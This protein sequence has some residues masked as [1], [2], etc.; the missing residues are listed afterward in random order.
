MTH[1]D[2]GKVKPI[3]FVTL[4][5]VVVASLTFL[6]LVNMSA[7][8]TGDCQPTRPRRHFYGRSATTSVTQLLSESDVVKTCTNLLSRLTTKNLGSGS[9][10]GNSSGS[11]RTSEFNGS[12]AGITNGTSATLSSSGLGNMRS[13]VGPDSPKVELKSQRKNSGG[14]VCSNSDAYNYVKYK[15]PLPTNHSSSNVGLSGDAGKGGSS[16]LS[17]S[18]FG[19][20]RLKELEQKFS[21]RYSRIF[22]SSANVSSPSGTPVG[23]DG[24]G[25]SSGGI[26]RENRN[27]M[28]NRTSLGSKDALNTI[29]NLNGVD[30]FRG[31]G[32]SKSASTCGGAL[33]SRLPYT[34][35]QTSAYGST[36]GLGPADTGGAYMDNGRGRLSVINLNTPTSRNVDYNVRRNFGLSKSA[37]S[38]VIQD[39]PTSRFGGLTNTISSA[40]PPTS[41]SSTSSTSKYYNPYLGYGSSRLYAS[42]S[43][44]LEPVPEQQQRPRIDN[45]GYVMT[46]GHRDQ[47]SSSVARSSTLNNL[48][49]ALL[50]DDYR[51]DSRAG[52]VKAES[53]EEEDCSAASGASSSGASTRKNSYKLPSRYYY[54]R[55]R[56]KSSYTAPKEASPLSF[57]N[58]KSSQ[59][60]RTKET[61]TEDED[62]NNVTKHTSNGLSRTSSYLS[63]LSNS[64]N[65]NNGPIPSSHVLAYDIPPRN[66][67]LRDADDLLYGSVGSNGT[68]GSSSGYETGGGGCDSIKDNKS[69]RDASPSIGGGGETDVDLIRKKEI[70]DLIRKYSGFTY[71]S[72]KY[73]QL[74]TPGVPGP[75]AES[76]G[77]NE[78]SQS[79]SSNN[80]T[81]SNKH[82]QHSSHHHL[83]HHHKPTNVLK[84]TTSHTALATAAT[85]ANAPNSSNNNNHVSSSATMSGAASYLLQNSA[86]KSG[87]VAAADYYGAGSGNHDTTVGESNCKGYLS[88]KE[89]N[90]NNTVIYNVSLIVMILFTYIIKMHFVAIGIMKKSVISHFLRGKVGRLLTHLLTHSLVCGMKM[91]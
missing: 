29:G 76:G 8:N 54:R 45:A 58:N 35:S 70:E 7:A 72:S 38:S 81:A 15:P 78:E 74:K 44:L 33:S 60:T 36:L 61:S 11:T 51:E 71:K 63:N 90:T 2:K 64:S 83:H 28:R 4:C 50:M 47:A 10:S 21:E 9:S 25:N 46:R 12:A 57:T 62:N 20:D 27:N 67:T 56:H 26:S 13:A 37:S 82:S 6:L 75:T 23:T 87:I 73:V 79:S 55:Y 59:S 22:G 3:L 88:S 42:N 34:G 68:T 31:Y 24:N 89:S 17:F 66:K 80:S 18:Y 32:L 52:T 41:G 14:S 19:N 16:R 53:A 85:S 86:S 1:N 84:T 39:S 65:L 48:D 30:D 49:R 91:R 69:K 40:I 5:I 43:H 77:Q